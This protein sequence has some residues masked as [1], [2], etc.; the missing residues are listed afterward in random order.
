[1]LRRKS[2][3][4]KLT[5]S[6]LKGKKFSSSDNGGLAL[7]IALDQLLARGLQSRSDLHVARKLWHML[8]GSTGLVAYV[9]LDNHLTHLDFVRISLGIGLVALLVDL[10]R[11]RVPAANQ[12]VIKL[13]GPF[14]RKSEVSGPSGMPFFALGCACALYFASPKVGYL[15]IMFLVF[16]DPIASAVGIRFGKS[17]IVEGKSFEGS[18]A[19]FLVCYFLS[20][21]YC[22]QYNDGTWNLV[23]FSLIAGFIGAV[24]ELLSIYIDDNFT[25]PVVSAIGIEQL[26]SIFHLL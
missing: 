13:M 20:L 10:I 5:M 8:I 24:S 18:L 21:G 9:V 7:R 23:A 14:M 22:L 6:F 15:A 25:I 1:M 16:S 12:A 19:C 4:V 3:D 17:K 11:L 26:N 2:R